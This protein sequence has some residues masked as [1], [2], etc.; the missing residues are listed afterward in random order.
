M[1]KEIATLKDLES[2]GIDYY[3]DLRCE[4]V[5]TL[6]SVITDFE[7]SCD[8]SDVDYDDD[9]LTFLTSILDRYGRNSL[10]KE[11]LPFYQDDLESNQSKDGI[12]SDI[13]ELFINKDE[14]KDILGV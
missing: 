14:L 3:D 5:F 8:E 7:M 12:E 4:F 1:S 13:V 6:S 2:L 9:F 10:C 11:L